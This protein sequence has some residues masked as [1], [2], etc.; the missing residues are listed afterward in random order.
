MRMVFKLEKETKNYMKFKQEG[1][2]NSLYLAKPA[3]G[4][5][6]IEQEFEI[7]VPD[8]TVA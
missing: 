1:G 6:S 3:E 2:I 4:V 5:P 7:E 8:V